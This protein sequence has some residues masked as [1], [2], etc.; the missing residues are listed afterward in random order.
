MAE[1]P[2][3]ER[4]ESQLG[5][6]VVQARDGTLW[7]ELNLTCEECGQMRWRIP[8]HHIQSVVRALSELVAAYPALTACGETII[9]VAPPGMPEGSG[10]VN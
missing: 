10:K 3:R 1:D 4:A 6:T 8:G 2:E 7:A 5:F 9:G